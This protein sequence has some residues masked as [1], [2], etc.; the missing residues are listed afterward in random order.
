M[1]FG[2]I[3]SKSLANYLINEKLRFSD[4]T[5]GPLILLRS[6]LDVPVAI[7]RSYPGYMM[8]GTLSAIVNS[9]DGATV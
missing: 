5:L 3:C 7:E 1:A 2:R 6:V 9:R 4:Q 8:G